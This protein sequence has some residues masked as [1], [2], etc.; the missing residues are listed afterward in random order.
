[1]DLHSKTRDESGGRIADVHSKTKE[2]KGMETQEDKEVGENRGQSLWKDLE[3]DKV[4]V[5]I[6]FFLYCLQG[7]PVGLKNSIP[8]LLT[9]RSVPYTEQAIF[10]I[11]SYPWSMKVFNNFLNFIQAFFLGALGSNCRLSVLAK[12]W[13]EKVLDCAYAVFTW[14]HFVDFFSVYDSLVGRE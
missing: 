1:M 8:L 5:C 4:H 13:K 14:H 7:I 10:S 11:A 12:L 6:L 3:G 2:A 9:R